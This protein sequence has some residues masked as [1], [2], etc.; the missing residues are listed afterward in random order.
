MERTCVLQREEISFAVVSI[1]FI[2]LP[3][4]TSLDSL[5]I[6]LNYLKYVKYLC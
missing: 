6:V 5:K 3:N 4:Y 2:K 1:H